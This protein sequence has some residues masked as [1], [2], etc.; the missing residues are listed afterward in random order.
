MFGDYTLY[1]GGKVFG[2]VSDNGFY[3]KPTKAGRTLLRS[4]ELRPPYEGAKEH[5]YIEEVDD[6]DYISALVRATCNDLPTP[7]KRK[8]QIV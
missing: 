4:V 7:K 6:R 5:F 2:L 3:V 8:K 1:C